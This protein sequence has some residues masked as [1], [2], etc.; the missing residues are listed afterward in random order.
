MEYENWYNE[1]E[2]DLMI[3]YA[4]SGANGEADFDFE[5]FC[6]DKYKNHLKKDNKWIY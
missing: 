5:K 3:A 6:E 1:N 4:E 2:E